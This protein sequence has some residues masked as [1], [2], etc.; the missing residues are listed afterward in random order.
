MTSAWEQRSRCFWLGARLLLQQSVQ[1]PSPPSH[2]ALVWLLCLSLFHIGWSRRIRRI[3]WTIHTYDS[4]FHIGFVTFFCLPC[5][6]WSNTWISNTPLSGSRL[7]YCPDRTRPRSRECLSPPQSRQLCRQGRCIL[8]VEEGLVYLPLLLF[9]SVC[10]TS[11]PACSAPVFLSKSS[12]LYSYS[13]LSN[14][15]LRLANPSASLTSTSS[16]QSSLTRQGGPDSTARDRC[17]PP[18]IRLVPS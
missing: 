5:P 12:L 14:F 3:E 4:I 7:T 2:L 15:P 16:C 6:V 9:S 11:A 18:S 17:V 1:K 8:G 13:N 10:A